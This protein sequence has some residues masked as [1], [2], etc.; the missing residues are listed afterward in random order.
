MLAAEV[1]WV[2]GEGTT[3]LVKWA[4]WCSSWPCS[5]CWSLGYGQPWRHLGTG[6]MPSGRGLLSL[7][8]AKA[9]D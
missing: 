9:G 2:K 7:Y 4:F 5:C 3:F 1:R 8:I 6:L